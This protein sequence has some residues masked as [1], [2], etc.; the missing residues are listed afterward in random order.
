MRRPPSSTCISS[1]SSL[2]RSSASGILRSVIAD[3]VIQALVTFPGAGYL[4]LARAAAAEAF[5]STSAAELRGV[6]FLQPLAVD[7]PGLHV[8]CTITDGRFEIRS[9]DGGSEEVTHCSGSVTPSAH[10]IVHRVD[11]ALVRAISCVRTA[12]VLALYNG[13]DAVGL[14]YGP[15]YRTLERAWSSGSSESS[16]AV[17]AANTRS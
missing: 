14:Q 4:E 7:S 5:S 9:G 2:F 10:A 11:H 1:A 3:H 15:G 6:F 8:D 13:F 16:A 12:D 17:D